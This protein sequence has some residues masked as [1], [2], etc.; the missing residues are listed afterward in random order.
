VLGENESESSRSVKP[1]GNV[2]A[3]EKSIRSRFDSVVTV[4]TEDRD[5][6]D[7]RRCCSATAG[8][9]PVMSSTLGAPDGSNSRRAYGATDSK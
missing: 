3:R 7:P 1:L 5:E 6:A 4:P 8:G 9:N 2:P